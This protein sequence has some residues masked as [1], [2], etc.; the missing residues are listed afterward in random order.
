VTASVAVQTPAIR[1]RMWLGVALLVAGFLGHYFAARAIGGTYIAYRDHMAGFFILTLVSGGIIALLGRYFW[2]GR[3]D[4]TLL[5]VGA[6][7]AAIGVFVYVNRFSVH[8]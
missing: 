4:I 1:T 7:Q 3:H 8:G 2:R 6:I 5:A